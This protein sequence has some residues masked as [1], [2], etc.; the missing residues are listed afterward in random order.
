MKFI[1]KLC[2]VLAATV[3][4][5]SAATVTF[6]QQI[7]PIIYSKC[8]GCHRAGETAPFTLTS[9]KDVAKRGA[10]IAAVTEKRF[11]PPWPAAPADVSYRDERRLTD[12]Q[13]S[14]LQAWVKQ[15]MPEGDPA[16]ATALPSFPAGWQLGEPDVI[17]SFPHAYRIPASG[18][19][20]YRDFV[21]PVNLPED[22]WIRAIELRPSAPKAMHHVLYYGDPSGSMRQKDNSESLPG[23]AGLDLPRGTLSLGVW[24]AGTQPHLLPDGIARPFPKG[25]DL[26]LQEHFHPTGKEEFEKTTVGIYFAKQAPARRMVSVQLPINFGFFAGVNIPAGE[27][28]FTVRDSFTLPIDVDAF[29]VSAHAHYIG[30]S[31]KLTATLPNGDVKVLLNIPNWDFAWQDGY[32]FSD[33]AALPKGTR[34]DGEVVWDNSA[35]NIRNPSSPPVPVIWGER[36]I[37]EMGS[38]T[39]D[40]LAHHEEERK[41][42]TDALSERARRDVDAAY[43]RDP[44][45][46]SYYEDLIGNRTAVFQAGEH[47]EH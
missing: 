20:I 4:C 10:Q 14:L 33:M 17:V 28:N 22:K 45:L 1:A 8:A 13:I 44:S 24:A 23:F 5:A 27:K 39:L 6:N 9:Y 35:S 41:V 47:K 11:M 26:I 42:L 46:K 16:T 12:Q 40:L 21:I 37:D 2:A 38:V 15:G 19:D 30:K 34:L 43:K 31:V 36:T 25:S 7:A 29:G 18:P 3:C 32:I